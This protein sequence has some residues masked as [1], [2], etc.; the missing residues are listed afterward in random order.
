MNVMPILKRLFQEN[1]IPSALLIHGD[2]ADAHQ[3]VSAFLQWICCETHESCGSCG[4]CVW[5]KEGH[6]PDVL[7]ISA[8]QSGHA[9]KIDQIRE[10]QQ[11]SYQ[12]PTTGHQWAVIHDAGSMNLNSANA[13]LKVLEEPSL[14]THFILTVD[15]ER[16]L[17]KTILS[18]CVRYELPKVER[19]SENKEK[20][21]TLKSDFLILLNRYLINEMDLQ[22][23]L[24]FFE[25][26]SLDDSL[27]FCQQCCSEMVTQRLLHQV[28]MDALTWVY[29]VPLAN[30]WAFWDGILD[31]RQQLRMGIH[32]HPSL[33][34]THLFLTLKIGSSPS[35]S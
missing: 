33:L 20:L 25:P 11:W 21:M 27:W 7:E 3:L 9:I 16:L 4:A 1:R 8:H 23:L 17:P 22:A 31:Y 18:R 2:L 29:A 14:K 6:H 32:F 19:V 5:L 12:A 26:H 30:W 10:L 13:L 24:Q 28:T 34:F 15:N 35:C